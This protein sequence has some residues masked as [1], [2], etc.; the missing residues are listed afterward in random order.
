ML[1]GLQSH[2]PATSGHRDRPGRHDEGCVAID[3]NEDVIAIGDGKFK[4]LSFRSNDPVFKTDPGV[5]PSDEQ[6]ESVG[7]AVV[8]TPF[9][10]DDMRDTGPV[11]AKN[12]IEIMLDKFLTNA[13]S[14]VTR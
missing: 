11:D 1:R 3:K 4:I 9:H 8:Q 7:I 12:S 14:E 6:R 2:P 10:H 5:I 13:D